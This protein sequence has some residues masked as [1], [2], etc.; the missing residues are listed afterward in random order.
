[1][2][3]GAWDSSTFLMASLSGRIPVENGL[4]PNILKTKEIRHGMVEV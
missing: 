4:K 3:T 1:M 2:E